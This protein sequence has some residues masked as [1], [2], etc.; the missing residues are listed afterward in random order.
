[1][2]SIRLSEKHGVNPSLLQCPLCQKDT[3]VALYGKLQGDTEAPRKSLDRDPCAECQVHMKQ[4]IIL[5]E[6]IPHDD[7]I[8]FRGGYWVITEAAFRRIFSGEVAE[9]GLALRCC[10]ID[11]EAADRIGLRKQESD[12]NSGE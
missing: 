12:N 5:V 6:A 7:H 8:E 3:G 9:Q 4:G 2:S 10:Y 11:P 1:M